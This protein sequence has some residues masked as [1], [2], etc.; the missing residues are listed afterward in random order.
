M[1]RP[2]AAHEFELNT[3][4]EFLN[5]SLAAAALLT[6]GQPFRVNAQDVKSSSAGSPPAAGLD[7]EFFQRAAS[8][9]P[10][11]AAIA[12]QFARRDKE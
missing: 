2:R 3:G 7:G 10:G 8:R 9:R 12:P 1:K 11:T 4:R 6:V 5:S